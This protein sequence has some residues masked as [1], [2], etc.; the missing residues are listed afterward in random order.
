MAAHLLKKDQI[1]G[2]RIEFCIKTMCFPHNI[3]SKVI[4]VK[5]PILMLEHPPY[6]PDLSLH[7]F[8]TFPELQV[9]LRGSHFESLED[10]RKLCWQYGKN[11][12]KIFSSIVSRCDRDIR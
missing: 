1:F 10:I 4:L 9:S 7:D 5:K 12:Q 8:F 11:F 6:L 2:Y 3:F